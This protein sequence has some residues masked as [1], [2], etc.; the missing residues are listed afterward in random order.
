MVLPGSFEFPGVM[1]GQPQQNHFQKEQNCGQVLGW[2]HSLV[3]SGLLTEEQDVGRG[4]DGIQNTPLKCFLLWRGVPQEKDDQL[5]S[6]GKHLLTFPC[7][8]ISKLYTLFDSPEVLVSVELLHILYL[9]WLEFGGLL[10]LDKLLAAVSPGN[11][12]HRPF[13]VHSSC[14]LDLAQPSDQR[15]CQGELAGM[16]VV[17]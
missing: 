13:D 11:F 17:A 16:S 6:Q 1:L 2:L 7:S 14:L 12:F 15:Q 5:C 4:M 3:V 8:R 9:A 10:I